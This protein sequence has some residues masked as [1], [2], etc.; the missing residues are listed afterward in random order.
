MAGRRAGQAIV[1]DVR[2]GGKN[3]SPME[4]NLRRS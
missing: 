4:K 1:G 3:H 2:S